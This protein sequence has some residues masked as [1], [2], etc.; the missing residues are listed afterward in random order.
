MG[1]EAKRGSKHGTDATSTPTSQEQN[2]GQEGAA[3]GL[4]SR[5]SYTLWAGMPKKKQKKVARGTR[6]V[7]CKARTAVSVVEP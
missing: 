6:P 3:C 7:G 5:C 4:H 2:G 1:C